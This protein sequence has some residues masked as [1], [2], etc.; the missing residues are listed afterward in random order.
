M[1]N[2]ISDI[3]KTFR[4]L[5][6]DIFFCH[7]LDPEANIQ[8]VYAVGRYFTR[9]RAHCPFLMI[10]YI[11]VQNFALTGFE[12]QTSLFVCRKNNSKQNFMGDVFFV[13]GK[14]NQ[15]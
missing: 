5:I 15:K 9:S 14:Q 2:N 8:K 10:S 1:A 13:F 3:R 4:I 11:H 7:I 12:K 6:S